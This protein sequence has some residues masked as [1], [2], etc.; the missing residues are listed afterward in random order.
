VVLDHDAKEVARGA[1]G[2]SV[3]LPPGQYTMQTHFNGQDFRQTF[4]INGGQQTGVNF[5]AASVSGPAGGP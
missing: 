1:F 5:N 2:Q 4:W 3:S